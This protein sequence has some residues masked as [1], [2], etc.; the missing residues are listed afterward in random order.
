MDRLLTVAATC[1]QND[2]C[3]FEG[4]DMF[5]EIKITN[6]QNTAVGFPL[7][8]L[9]QTGPIVRLVD[10]L[11][12]A[13][14]YVRTNLADIDLREKLTAIPPGASI[15]LDY[16]ISSAEL[17]QFGGQYVD[18]SAEI[19]VMAETDIL[20][21][22]VEFRGSDTLRIVSKDKERAIR[23]FHRTPD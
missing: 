16:V 9:Q 3:V 12:R 1:R 7:T 2:A 13:E 18:L 15:T 23:E 14:S 5:L 19:T 8:Y 11:T 21:K 17:Q 4:Q 6:T 20:G 22:R 10:T